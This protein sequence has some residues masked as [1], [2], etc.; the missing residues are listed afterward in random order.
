MLHTKNV[1]NKLKLTVIFAGLCIIVTSCFKEKDIKQ[2]NQQIGIVQFSPHAGPKNTIVNISGV[3]FPDKANI[4]VKVNGKP[5]PIVAGTSNNIQIQIPQG[6]G[7]GK[8]EVTFGGTTYDAGN[9]TYQNTYTLTSLT[10][11]QVGTQNGPLASASFEDIES[12]AIDANNN[13]YVGNYYGTQLRKINLANSTVSTLATQLGG[14]EFLSVDASANVYYVDEDNNQVVKVT[15]AGVSSVL[16]APTFGIQAIKVGASGNIY[17]AGRT[18]IVKYSPAGAVLWRLTSHGSGNV[19]GDT[20]VVRFALYG[21]IDVDATETKIY[22]VQNTLV[23]AAGYPSQIKLLD[24]TAKK[25]TTLAGSNTVGG[26]V[27]GSGTD[28]EFSLAYG[29]TLDKQ[30]G[31]YIADA[32][33]GAIRYLKDG[34]VSTVI[35]GTS[36]GDREGAG[37]AALL[38]S[39]QHVAFDS[40]GVMYIADWGNNKIYKVVID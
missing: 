27:D 14:A 38:N 11:G 39:P 7:S 24:L 37:T 26:L 34:V 35:G 16:V 2:V 33:T 40:N 36:Y 5:T 6:T 10:N 1:L 13:M 25:I 4:Q 22:L 28:A 8:L 19:D 23:A 15:P 3:N 9:F 12:L 17:V 32:G 30:G 31:A 29:V 21:Q 20:S 18:N